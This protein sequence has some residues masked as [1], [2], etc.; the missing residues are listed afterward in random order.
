M[1]DRLAIDLLHKPLQALARQR[2]C[3]LGVGADTVTL[4]GFAIGLAVLRRSRCSTRWP[5]W[6]CCW[7]AGCATAW[8]ARWRG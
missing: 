1:L 3:G 4:T 8:T 5:G 6:R 7:P 2:W